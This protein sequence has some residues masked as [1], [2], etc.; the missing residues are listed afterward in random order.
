M[1]CWDTILDMERI[2]LARLFIW[3]GWPGEQATDLAD[4]RTPIGRLLF[5]VPTLAYATMILLAG[6][7]QMVHA[8]D[9]ATISD[10]IVVVLDDSSSMRNK[11]RS[12]RRIVKMDAAKDALVQVLKTLPQQTHVGV[13]TLHDG[14]DWT[15]PLGPIDSGEMESS[16]RAITPQRG[17]P[18]G[19]YLKIASDSLLKLR[20]S[21][22]YGTY[23]LLI[24]TDGEAN[25]RAQVENYL[26]DI[27]ARGIT[28]DVIGV[29][30]KSDHSLATKVH[31]Y[32][33]ANDA[34]SLSDALSEVLAESSG[35]NQTDTDDYESLDGISDAVA[36][37]MVHALGRVRNHPIG[38]REPAAIPTSDEQVVRRQSAPVG[39][40]PPSNEAPDELGS[41]VESETHGNDIGPVPSG[42]TMKRR[43][44]IFILLA[45]MGG[46]VVVVVLV[47]LRL[48][49]R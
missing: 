29:D 27:L 42:K 6:F 3:C 23:R 24:V 39:V 44:W 4:S 19:K 34:A 32:R 13:V 33:R 41:A 5:Q 46:G 10:N 14:K 35:S 37:A 1:N 20:E 16:I 38:E 12:N 8:S 18:L 21:Q 48:V 25:D 40:S 15:V 26:P 11:L 22:R 2:D 28:V 36:L 31:G 17:T 45:A 43:K 47:V 9:S 7:L 30:M 49:R